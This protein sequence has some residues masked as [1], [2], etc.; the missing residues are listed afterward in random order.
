MCMEDIRLGRQTGRQWTA[1]PVGAA[2]ATMI[3]PPDPRRTAIIIGASADGVVY[4][5]P[6]GDRPAAG[7]GIMLPQ[8]G[9][10]LVLDLTHHGAIVTAGWYAICPAGVTHVGVATATLQRE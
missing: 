4:I 1:A 7:R 8:S 9:P 5:A 3:A 10:P 6:E 2:A